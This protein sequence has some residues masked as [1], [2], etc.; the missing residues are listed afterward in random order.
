MFK[1]SG[2]KITSADFS[3]DS[4]TSLIGVYTNPS[5]PYVFYETEAQA[6]DRAERIAEALNNAAFPRSRYESKRAFRAGGA[7]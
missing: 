1:M 5:K 2:F 3:L 7:Q 4:A 6:L